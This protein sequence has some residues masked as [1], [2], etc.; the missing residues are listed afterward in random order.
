MAEPAVTRTRVADAASWRAF[1]RRFAGL[2]GDFR[3]DLYE[4]F[5]TAAS[6]ETTACP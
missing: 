1:T 4:Q 6:V 5:R 2:A 3:R